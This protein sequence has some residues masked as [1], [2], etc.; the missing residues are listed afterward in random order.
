MEQSEATR[1]ISDRSSR[2]TAGL[3]AGR[4]GPR[5]LL[6]AIRQSATASPRCSCTAGPA[7]GGDVNARRFF[8]PDRLPHRDLRSARLGAQPPARVARRAN[9]TWDLVADMEAL[10]R[11][12]GI[13]RWLVF[14]G[15]WGST[16]ALA[17]AETHPARRQRARAARHLPAAAQGARLVLSDGARAC[18]SP[19]SGRSSSRRFR[20]SERGDLLGAYHRRLLGRRSAADA[21]RGRARVVHLGRGDELA[22]AESRSARRNSAPE[23]ALALAR[24]EAHY[25]VNHGFFADEDQLLRGVDRIRH[26]PAVIVQGR[27]DVVCP[28]ET[29]WELHERWPEADFRIVPDAGH[30][31]YEPGITAR[32]RRRDGSILARRVRH[33]ERTVARQCQ[34]RQRGA[35]RDDRCARRERSHRADRQWACSGA[36]PRSSIFA[37]C[38]CCPGLIDDQVHCRE[39]GLTHKAT[40]ATESLAAVC[41]GVTS[42]LDM[43]NTTPPTD[44]SYGARGEEAHRGGD[45][46]RE[47]RVLPR[48][49]QHE[50]RGDQAR[51]A[52]RTPAASKCSWAH[53]PATCWSTTRATLEAIFAEARLPVATHCEDSPLIWENE[54]RYARALRRRCPD[55]RLTPRSAPPRP[56]TSRRRSRSDLASRHGTRLHVL[57]LSTARELALFDPGPI[58][59]KRITAEACV[60]HLWFDESRYADLGTRIKCNPAIKTAA[61]RKASAGCACVRT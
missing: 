31:A 21:A 35:D 53:R 55:R 26:I 49:D 9:T 4:L 24:I 46:P 12:L 42:F 56:A 19:S 15:S 10:R 54:R 6:R 30:S 36:A 61:D 18:C 2:S 38:T 1:A 37:G 58:E 44:R 20:R 17:Y 23:F 47:L 33:S 45:V 29:A 27:Y 11:R 57:H 60:H 40:L 41:G 52:R 5:D 51:R 48:R 22:L 43:P 3:S 14:G 50:S 25:F 34:A 32:A 28:I 39:P 16:L 7:R 13:E 59:R 8:D